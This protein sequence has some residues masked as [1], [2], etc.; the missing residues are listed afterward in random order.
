MAKKTDSNKSSKSK[1]NEQGKSRNRTKDKR[2]VRNQGQTRRR[3]DD[4]DSNNK[5]GGKKGNK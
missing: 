5:E 1:I 4:G 3:I 2:L